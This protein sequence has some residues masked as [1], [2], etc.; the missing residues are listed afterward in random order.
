M[1]EFMTMIDVVIVVNCRIYDPNGRRYC[2]KWA[3]LRPWSTS[4]LWPMVE[5]MDPDVCRYCG[6]LPDIRP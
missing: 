3:D 6:H 5:L 1:N 2:C 4:L